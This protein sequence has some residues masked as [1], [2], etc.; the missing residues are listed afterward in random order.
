MNNPKP[1]YTRQMVLRTGIIAVL[2]FAAIALL[3]ANLVDI[4]I[5]KA[6]D[7]RSKAVEQYT[8]EV[9]INPNRGTIYDRNMKPLAVSAT[10][11][12]VFISPKE[13]DEADEVRIADYLSG[14]LDADRDK[15]LEKMKNKKS[16]YYSVKK[17]VDREVTD[18]IRAWMI[19]NGLDD[20]IHF[21]ETTKRYYPYGKL[22]SHVLGFTGADN[23]GLYGIEAKYENVLK[24][25]PGKL[26]TAKNGLNEN[27]P[28]E[29]EDYIGAENGNNV[30]LTIDWTIQNFLEKALDAA[31]ADTKAQNRVLGIVMDVNTCEILAMSVKPDYDPNDPFT[32]DEAS[33]ALLDA[34]EGDETEKNDYR[35]ELLDTLWKNKC[36]TELYEPGS[37]FKLVTSAIALEENKVSEND[38]FYCSGSIMVKGW[39]VPIDCHNTSGHGTET[40]EEALQNS[41]NPVFVQL[42]QRIGKEKFYRY[43]EDFGLMDITGVD[44]P[45]EASG[46]YHSNL[47][48]FNDVELASYSFGQTFVI[49]PLRLLTSVCAVANGGN[50]MQ[51]YVVKA[52]TDADGNILNATEPKLVRQ[53]VSENTSKT[54][55]T[56]LKNGINIG[57]TKNAYVKGYDVAAKTG[58]AE[59]H[60]AEKD[61]AGNITPYVGSCVAFAPADDPQIA[62]LIAIDTPTNGQIYGGVV[63]APVVSQVLTDTLPY[64]NIAPT[65]T[66]EE[67]E[68][69]AVPVGDYRAITVE[70]AKE[71]I[72]EDGFSWKVFGS[73]EVV[74]E[75]FPRSGT[76]LSGDG[77]VILYTE[78]AVPSENATVPNCLGLSAA[79]ANQ[80]VINANLNIY[81]EGSYR[82]GVG[83]ASAV[84]VS[85]SPSAG[86]SVR[87]GTVVTVSFKH[88]DGTD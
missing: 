76:S 83:G 80:A 15:M 32:L 61:K 52:I 21:E 73:G 78:G 16:E 7:Y 36:I 87:P 60:G 42:G 24:G 84:A 30:V 44:L 8:R 37:T 27:M 64:L 4:Q 17:K 69:M 38:T 47:S 54:I 71:Q 28:F 1:P 12:N 88:L 82:E 75:Q 20:G 9:P 48:L 29:Y 41:C 2:L 53:I 19:E 13:I 39:P 62:I 35:K 77:V 59:K 25:A 14:L 86:E 34:F 40:F 56:Y 5:I 18:A 66:D 58:T 68:T 72:E 10:I 67:K 81:I 70:K 43:F 23:N 65:L 31:L 22:A 49:T 33:Q 45:G 74:S 6:D 46:I 11:E 55:M 79:A 85:Q 51:P 26:I 57:S 3:F 50:L 63:A